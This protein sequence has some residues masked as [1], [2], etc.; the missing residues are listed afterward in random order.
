MRKS[1]LLIIIPLLLFTS[2]IEIFEEVTVNEDQSGKVLIGI[3]LGEIGKLLN[4]VG[5]Y[6]DTK[7]LDEIKS[8]PKQAAKILK[9]TEGIKKIKSVTSDAKGLYSFSFEFDNTKDL[10]R[11][12]YE[13]MSYEKKWY[14]PKIYKVGKNIVKKRNI[15][16]FIRMYVNRK[17]SMIKDMKILEKIT[18]KS[19]FKLP[20]EVKKNTNPK[21]KLE[22]SK[23]NLVYECTLDELLNSKIDIGTKIRY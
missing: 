19:T 11:A 22:N 17:Q 7:F 18:Y 1:L 2:C 20:R 12:Y 13:L 6:I 16:P 8:L 21:Y 14:T 15:A 4:K 3:D 9:D 10:N 5:D 23:R